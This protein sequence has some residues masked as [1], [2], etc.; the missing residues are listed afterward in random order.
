MN[1]I[2]NVNRLF[3]IMLAASLLVPMIF[4]RWIVGL[5][6][7]WLLVISQLLYLVPCLVYLGICKVPVRK[8]IPFV[9]LKISTVFMI[10]LFTILVLPLMSLL[11]MISMLFVENVI[12]STTDTMISNPIWVNLIFLAL[13]PAFS[14]EFMFRGIFYGAYRKRGFLAGALASGFIFG[15]AHMN[16]NQFCYAFALGFAMCLLVEVTGSILSS[17]VMHFLVN[18]LSVVMMWVQDQLLNGTS[19]LGNAVKAQQQTVQLSSD[20]TIQMIGFLAIVALITTALAGCVLVWIS[21]NCHR[22]DR[23]QEIFR[24]QPKQMLHA[25][26][27]NQDGTAADSGNRRIITI[28]FGAACILSFIFMI[29]VG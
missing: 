14:E 27:A 2:K 13:M 17:M 25:E 21:K 3:L 18:G 22:G 8:E 19:Q 11:N 12:G 1:K 6:T 28:A 10:V 16:L 5:G 4:G 26:P 29:Y 15:M 7:I 23:L 24:G 9:R 20:E